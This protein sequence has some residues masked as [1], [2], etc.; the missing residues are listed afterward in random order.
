MN[1]T[2][3]W[4]PTSLLI[5]FL[6]AMP[7]D[8]QAGR[9]AEIY[10]RSHASVVTVEA[11]DS[12]GA[13]VGTGTAFFVAPQTLITNAHVVE[14][15]GTLVVLVG[16]VA[17]PCEVSAL[18]A[19]KDLAIL[20]TTVLV[21]VAPLQLASGD[22]KPGAAVF[23]LGSPAGMDKTISDGLF[24]GRRTVADREMIQISAPVSSGSS[25]SPV[26]SESGEVIGVIALTRR[27]AQ[28]LNFAVPIAD[29]KRLLAR[30]SNTNSDARDLLARIQ[31]LE[32][33][34]ATLAFSED[35][36]SEYQ[37]T[38]HKIMTS[39]RSAYAASASD[40]ELLHEVCRA[41]MFND[42]D[43]AVEA[44][45]RALSQTRQPSAELRRSSAEALYWAMVL[46]DDNSRTRQF[47]AEA[48]RALAPILA[49]GSSPGDLLLAGRIAV[50]AG[51]D[52]TAEVHLRAAAKRHLED[53]ESAGQ[54]HWVLTQLNRRL[55]RLELARGHFAAMEILVPASHDQLT[56]FAEWLSQDDLDAE[57]AR[58]FVKAAHAAK[59]PEDRFNSLAQAAL[60]YGYAGD[61][62]SNLRFSRL[63]VEASTRVTD[64]DETLGAVF[65]WMADSLNTRG[66]HEEALS[67]AKSAAALTPGDAWAYYQMALALDE[68][69][70]DNEAV[71]A[72]NNAIRLSD[73]RYASMH[74]VLGSALFDLERWD[75]AQRAFEKASSVNPSDAAAPFNVALCLKKR[76]YYRDAARWFEEVLRRQPNHPQRADLL[77]DI[78][79]LRR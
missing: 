46:E 79:T 47:A 64:V 16:P 50:I 66:V 51:D 10:A 45:R 75:Q 21:D 14:G 63:A 15:A 54:A 44:C 49:A 29:V 41:A 17:V 3:I 62:D 8:V 31:A 19:R 12:R 48:S 18:D 20:R 39:L 28:N 38:Q 60:H 43:L 59:T 68:L 55:K 1:R 52:A 56:T 9:G 61:I 11:R 27:E 22:P 74:F 34:Q 78:E 24:T 58:Y 26:F 42:Y 57:A 37:I 4:L 65:L 40:A 25:G 71:V 77:R 36:A 5:A 23:T 32:A 2:R 69:S 35:E 6:I 7:S 72:A 13:A 30:G 73:G 67:Y 33:L 76:G 70:R 53:A